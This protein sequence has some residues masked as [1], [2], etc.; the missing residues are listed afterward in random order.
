MEKREIIQDIK[1]QFN[2][3]GMLNITEV[4][5]YLGRSRKRL[6]PFLEGLEYLQVGS[7]KK[8]LVVDIAKKIAN[9]SQATG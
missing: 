1:S 3:A 2:G 6:R 5:K 9:E 4:A 8:Y 7:E